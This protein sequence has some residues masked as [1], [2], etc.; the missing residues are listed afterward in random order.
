MEKTIKIEGMSCNHCV[1]SV[2][3]K[4]SK[5]NLS[6]VK[7]EIGFVKIEFDESNISENDI[8]KAVEE[9]GYQVV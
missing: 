8:S 4:L 3:K 2:E 9:A 6:N 7:V 5:L 1:M